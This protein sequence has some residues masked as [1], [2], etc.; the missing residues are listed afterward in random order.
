MEMLCR[1]SKLV[2]M[3][4]MSTL[5]P[6]CMIAVC[7]MLL[8]LQA[9]SSQ[10][11]LRR[12]SRSSN[13]PV[14]VTSA[15]AT[16]VDD[17]H[18]DDHTHWLDDHNHEYD[19]GGGFL[20]ELFAPASHGHFTRLG[21][22]LVHLFLTE[23]AVLHRDVFLDYRVGNNFDGNT[24]E[25]ELEFEME[26]AL[27]KRLG[28]VIEV[29]YVG[30]NAVADP[31]TS[32]FADIAVAGRVLLFDRDAFFLSA[33]VEV[34]IPTGDSDQDLGRGEVALAPTITTWLD[35]GSWT[36]LHGQFGPEIGLDSGDTEFIHHLALTT[37]FQGPVLF[38][39]GCRCGRNFSWANGGDEH[40]GHEEHFAP[41]F[42]SLILEMTGATGLS[43]DEAGQ[44]VIDLLPG[45]AYTP[46]ERVEFRFGVRFPLFKPERLDTQ[47]IF[48]I[49]RVF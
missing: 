15:S 48:T 29:P 37:S 35:L 8:P 45:I 25:Q 36:A 40:E 17:E 32:G 49:A 5:T 27:T 10:D 14:M 16:V 30:L 3:N 47:Y 11:W 12:G 24:D 41:G 44:T 19:V 39:R 20:E 13:S 22:P 2:I 34:E 26:Y 1:R 43:G 23:P 33:N 9:A 31:N 28:M 4:V 18:Y 46:V 21:T 6:H 42:T 38:G 7:L